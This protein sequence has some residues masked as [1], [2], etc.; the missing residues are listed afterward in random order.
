M[1]RGTTLLELKAPLRFGEGDNGPTRSVLL[2]HTGCSSELLPGDGR[3]TACSTKYSAP[4]SS[5]TIS[6]PQAK[7][8]PLWG[9]ARGNKL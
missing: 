4:E 7:N 5:C 3:I 2:G 1:A 6:Y 9:L 8:F